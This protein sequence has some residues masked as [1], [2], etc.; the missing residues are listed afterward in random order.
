MALLSKQLSRDIA[1]SFH[2]GLRVNAL[3]P[4]DAKNLA[5]FLF[6]LAHLK[7]ETERVP[8]L[9]S[10]AAEGHDGSTPVPALRDED[11]LAALRGFLAAENATKGY[12]VQSAL[13]KDAPTPALATPATT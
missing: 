9:P 10:H 7:Q 13:L 4:D 1:Q 5:L 12:D 11:L 8:A 2:M 6:G 3:Q